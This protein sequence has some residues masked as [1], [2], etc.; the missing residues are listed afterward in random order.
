[1][2]AARSP[3]GE[4]LMASVQSGLIPLLILTHVTDE[5]GID[6]CVKLTDSEDETKLIVESPDA[7]MAGQSRLLRTHR[8]FYKGDAIRRAAQEFYMA[9]VRIAA[10]MEEEARNA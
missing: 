9:L 10:E 8:E 7:V 3:S 1:M 4:M 5:R 6:Y 2:L